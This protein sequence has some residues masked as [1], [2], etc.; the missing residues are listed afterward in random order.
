MTEVVKR[1]FD[2][3]ARHDLA[4][5]VAC[6]RP[7]GLDRF[8]AQGQEPLIAPAG[9]REYFANLFAA[10]PDFAFE[11]L[12]TTTEGARTAVRWR[13]TATFAGPGSFQGFEPTGARVAIEGCDVL[14]VGAD[15]L[16]EENHAY[17]DSG[18]IVRQL[19]FLPAL[20][21]PVATR[22]T[23]LANLRT[24]VRERVHGVDTERIADG[25]HVLR[26]GFPV[27]TMNVYLIEDDG[28]VTVFDAGTEDMAGGIAAAAARLGGIKRVVLGHSDCDHRGAAPRLGAPVYCHPAE[29]EAAASGDPMRS[30]WDVSKLGSHARLLLTRLFPIWDGG[31]VEIAGTVT[32]GEQIAGFGVIELAGHAPGLIGLFRAR[33][34]LALVSDAFY[35][36]D[37]QTGRKQPPHV[38]HPAFNLDTEQARASLR[39][40]AALEPSAAWAGHAD[41]VT[42]EVAFRLDSAASAPAP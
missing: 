10:F 6:W 38:P 21:S 16:I 18:A 41:P 7:G 27:R 33:D 37:L 39:K 36:L 14:T 3:L 1:Y 24:K 4:A 34:R 2:A 17:V 11:V 8:A 35:T 19:G 28:G 22:L 20:E 25:V 12:D 29:R 31:P 32:E 26:G 15:G 40:L 9:V 13:A 23:K 42:T 30:Y 5:A